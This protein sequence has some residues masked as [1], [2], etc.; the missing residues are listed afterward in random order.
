MTEEII[1]DGV[2]VAGCE[3]IAIQDGYIG[4][5]NNENGECERCFCAFKKRYGE[6]PQ[7]IRLDDFYKSTALILQDELHRLKQEN[8]TLKANAS[9]IQE[10]IT[11][12]E[13][14]KTNIDS[15]VKINER[16]KQENK[17]LKEEKLYRGIDK[18]FIEDANDK[19]YWENKKYRSA[20][21]EIRENLVKLKT[22]DEDD[23]TY[24]YSKIEDKI[25]EVLQWE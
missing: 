4:C 11:K 2:N 3:Y 24:E 6:T 18:Q 25:N 16:L 8:K 23:F 12:N 17:E 20:L 15:L 9:V 13:Q 5:T 19:L 7:T 21:E 14:L 22:N 1:I 10:Y